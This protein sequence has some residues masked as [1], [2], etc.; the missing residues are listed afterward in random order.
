M[1]SEK[2]RITVSQRI[3]FANATVRDWTSSNTYVMIGRESPWGSEDELIETPNESIDYLNEVRRSSI[4]IK[5]I[6][7]S[8]IAFVVPRVDWETGTVF[9]EV[10]PAID[11]YQ[12]VE[13][14]A[15]D[16]T[17]NSNNSRTMTGTNTHFLSNFTNGDFVY[18]PGDGVNVDAQMRQVIAIIS[19]TSMNVNTAFAG[20]FI[21]NTAYK[22]VDSTPYYVQNFY[23]RNKKDQVFK[24]LFNANGAF[25]TVEPAI[26]IGGA[27]PE[28]SFIETSD[29]YKWKYLYTI[30]S[31]QKQKF[32]SAEWMPV[33]RESA[34]FASSV[35]GRIDVVEIVNPGQYY[36][37]NV[38]S[39]VTSILS[40]TGDGT[41]ATLNARV[42]ANGSIIQVDILDGGS[43]YTEAFVVINDIIGQNANIRI[44]VGPPGGHGFDPV[45][46]LGATNL[47][48]SFELVGDENGVLP[49]E[50]E[51]GSDIFDYR[52]IVVIKQPLLAV[53]GET[54][55]ANATQYS[56]VSI[57]RVQNLPIGVFYRMDEIVYQG[58]TL[59][60]ATFVARV[61]YWDET[62]NQIWVNN[63]S[64][65]FT[66]S[67]LIRGTVTTTPF[68]AFSIAEPDI[69]IFSGKILHVNNV[70]PISRSDDQIEQIK[71]MISF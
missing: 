15:V 32:F 42:N 48:L 59:D 39:N 30:P 1:I 11:M 62:N 45:E 57:V 65:T 49:T 21:Q 13:F 54:I 28:N 27:L 16:G 17:V 31:G 36:N 19:N 35:D 25:S 22:V 40:V 67:E 53:D 5:K 29:G 34:V 37:Q 69:D 63:I 44:L 26:T 3:L 61:V 56:T 4:A 2:S 41:G 12:T 10:D 60:D 23:C 64:G 70:E 7:G 20:E 50:A 43:G 38:A 14:T 52:Q 71:T 55:N 6:N 46:E 24:C 58:D 8:D 51:V 18:M 66:D 9:D 47:L 33:F 68:T